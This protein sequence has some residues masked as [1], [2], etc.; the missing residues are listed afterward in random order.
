MV[1][2]DLRDRR[3]MTAL[4]RY[5]VVSTFL[6]MAPKRGGYMPPTCLLARWGDC[7]NGG[8]QDCPSYGFKSFAASF[9]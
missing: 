3:M 1:D 9:A 5:Q 7:E 6:A 4:G 8:Q 2:D